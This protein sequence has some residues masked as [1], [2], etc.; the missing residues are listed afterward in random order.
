MLQAHAAFRRTVLD[1]A[2]HAAFAGRD[3]LS[4]LA[5][6]VGD[7]GGEILERLRA[8]RRAVDGL[9]ENGKHVSVTLKQSTSAPETSFGSFVPSSSGRHQVL[10]TLTANGQ[11]AANQRT[12]FLV[13]GSDLELSNPETNR[14]LLRSIAEKSGGT[15]V[16][17]D[18]IDK[19]ADQLP[20]RE[21]QTRTIERTEFW[22][23]PVLFLV[24]LATISAEW[25]LR[26]RGHLV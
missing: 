7:R 9:D 26:R 15:Y 18:Q 20:R 19:L 13:V 2:G 4:D 8:A 23:S 11:A 5:P 12:E 25:V 16:D 10:A 21:R 6:H 17:I 22:N 24:F 14:A 1:P 3:Q